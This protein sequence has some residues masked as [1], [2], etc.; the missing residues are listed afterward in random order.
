MQHSVSEIRYCG[1][2]FEA[3]YDVGSTR[4]GG[5]TRLGYSAV[6]DEMHR[7]FE[8]LAR[9]LGCRVFA[10]EVGNT[11]A[12]NGEE[13]WALTWTPSSMGGGTTASQASSPA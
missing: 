13:G 7:C 2:L 6:E 4:E 1:E 8:A 10:D 12:S 9:E 5:V 3:F 11:F